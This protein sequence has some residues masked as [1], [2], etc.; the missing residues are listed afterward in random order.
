MP[1]TKHRK[2]QKKKKN[3]EEKKKEH[4]DCKIN[5]SERNEHVMTVCR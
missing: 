3:G 2:R 1:S 5:K 4:N